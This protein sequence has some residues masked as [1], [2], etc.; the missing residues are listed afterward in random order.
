MS[1]RRKM[2]HG[3]AWMVLFK[4]LERGLGVIGMLV[5]A[6][7][8][9]PA[10]FG[11]VAMATSL[12]A[13]LELF[14]NFGVDTALVQRA[15]AKEEHYHAA[16]SLNLLAAC[17]IAG[18]MLVLAIPAGRFYHEPR[19]VPVICVLACGAFLQGLEN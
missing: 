8:L 16:W 3:V 7:L 13:L 1:I 11:L 9:M 4:M 18:M 14:A 2:A 12:I 15:D 17:G 5:L 6:R 10:D 19:V